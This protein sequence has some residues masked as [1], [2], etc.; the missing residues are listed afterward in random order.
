MK[1]SQE[2]HDLFNQF[3]KAFD[4]GLGQKHEG[5]INRMINKDGSFNVKRIGI[6]HH[7]YQTLREMS[8][9]KF[10]SIILLLYISINILFAVVYLILGTE[11]LGGI[12]ESGVNSNFFKAFFFSMQTFTTGGIWSLPPTGFLDRVGGRT[13]DPQWMD[14]FCCGNGPCLWSF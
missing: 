3:F 12:N 2:Q 6:R 4:P 10:Y 14:L 13:R 7:L 1:E 11:N 8:R 9:A 5:K